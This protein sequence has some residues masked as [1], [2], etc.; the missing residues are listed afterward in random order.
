MFEQII[1]FIR[2]LYGQ[3]GEIPLHEPRFVGNEKTYVAECIDSTFVSSGGQFVEKV[4]KNLAAY[5]GATNA[6][7]V[8]NGTEALHVALLIAG[9]KPGDE[10]IT[11]P[12]TFVATCNAIT[13]C[14]ARPIF[15][16]VNRDTLGLSPQSLA[17]FLKKHTILTEKGCI[18]KTT[19]RIIRAC[20]PMHTF[21]HPARIDMIADIC[22]KHGLILIEDAAE[23]LGSFYKGRHT[24]T[25]G[26]LGVLSFNGNKIITCGGGGAILTNDDVLAQQA[27][28]LTTTAKQPH[29]YA[30]VHDQVGFNYRMPNLNAA[31]LVG[32]M[33]HIEMY[34]KNKRETAQR[35]Q[36]F[37]EQSDIAFMVEP[38]HSRSNYWLNALIFKDKNERN[39]FLTIS[40]N[41]GVK[42]RPF[43]RLMSRLPMYEKCQASNLS[44]A[45][46]LADRVV[47][48]P[49]SVR[50]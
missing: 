48:V 27:K 18:N 42:T 50:I 30:Y 34:L 46:W 7:A 44:N 11:Q 15:V 31:L 45:V 47:N 13:Y 37:C 21:G 24:G 19:K 5:T 2:S 4:E 36:S 33:E 14:G 6:V 40:N 3:Q 17:V 28:H 12:L 8:V 25:F 32:Q 20:V 29:D 35:Y 49:S 39:E 23:S 1:A 41:A 43:W 10:V 16:D 26:K 9:V 22:Q 38:V